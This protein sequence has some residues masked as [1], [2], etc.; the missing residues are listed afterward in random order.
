VAPYFSVE[1]KVVSKSQYRIDA[2]CFTAGDWN[3]TYKFHR[4]DKASLQAL[5]EQA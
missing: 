5:C 2:C 1:N 3:V 4:Q